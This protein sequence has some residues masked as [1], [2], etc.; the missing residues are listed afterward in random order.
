[1]LLVS[2]APLIHQLMLLFP[3]NVSPKERTE[4]LWK[5]TE[6]KIKQNSILKTS[7]LSE[8]IITKVIW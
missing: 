1:M 2:L 5:E 6:T 7:M 8:S 3:L 4:N